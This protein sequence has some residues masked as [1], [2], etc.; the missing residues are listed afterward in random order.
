MKLKHFRLVVIA[1]VMVTACK[2]KEADHAADPKPS[3]P[4]AE[5]A[6]AKP[7][8]PAPAPAAA[9]SAKLVELDL[10]GFGPAFKGYVATAPEGAKLD[11]SDPS[12]HIVLSDTDYVSVGEAPYWEDAVGGLAKDPDN[13]NIQ[14]VSAT[15][16]RYE[17]T[18]P[19]GT[20]WAVDIL[21]KVGDAKFSCTAGEPGTFTS[22]AMREQIANICKSIH[23]K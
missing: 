5:P 23:K 7:A 9:P 4:T 12:R 8:E 20:A 3:T 2:K 10:A 15:E 1:L 17:R 13:K 16:Y 18:P 22:A 11:F 14:K 19:L 21:V 6:A